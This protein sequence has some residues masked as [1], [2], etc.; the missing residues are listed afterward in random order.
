MIVNVHRLEGAIMEVQ[1]FKATLFVKR[2]K[3][4]CKKLYFGKM[5]CSMSPYKVDLNPKLPYLPPLTQ[6][7]EDN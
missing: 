1:G 4:T 2:A 3:K 6:T 7:R 5:I